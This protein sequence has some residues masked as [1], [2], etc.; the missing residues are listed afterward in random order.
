MPSLARTL[1]TLCLLL[2]AVG[3]DGGDVPLLLVGTVE[4][5]GARLG[6]PFATLCNT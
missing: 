4:R 2:A 5:Q 6:L 1:T 3:C